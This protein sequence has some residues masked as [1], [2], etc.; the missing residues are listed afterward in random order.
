MTPPTSHFQTIF[1]APHQRN[2]SPVVVTPQSLATSTLFPVSMDLSHLDISHKED[3]I[4]HGLC[5]LDA[6][7]VLKVTHVYKELALHASS[8]LSN[9]PLH[10]QWNVCISYQSAVGGHL[11]FHAWG[12]LRLVLL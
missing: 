5:G 10:I 3:C 1:T 7:R 11:G 12:L 6:F 2:L 9:I 4:A 8:L